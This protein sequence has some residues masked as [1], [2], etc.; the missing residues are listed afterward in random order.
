MAP[1]MQFWCFESFPLPELPDPVKADPSRPSPDIPATTSAIPPDPPVPPDP[2]DVCSSSRLSDL[3]SLPQSSAS[4]SAPPAEHVSSLPPGVFYQRLLSPSYVRL[5][6]FEFVDMDCVHGGGTIISA[7]VFSSG[8]SYLWAWPI[9]PNMGVCRLSPFGP[10]LYYYYTSSW[11][12]SDQAIEP[13]R[14]LCVVGVRIYLAVM[15]S[16]TLLWEMFNISTSSTGLERSFPP[17]FLIRKRPFP[18]CSPFMKELYFSDSNPE[19][20]VDLVTVLRS[21]VA[22]RTGPEETTE[23]ISVNFGGEDWLSTSRFKVTNFQQSGFAVKC[24]LTH[25]SLDSNS[26]SNF[27]EVLPVLIALQFM[28]CLMDLRGCFI[29]S[30]CMFGV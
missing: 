4:S 2:P 15:F 11:S 6:E 14:L 9:L 22:V 7:I 30:S 26:L 8:Y 24:C 17:S 16:S 1:L 21:C 5:C 29:P 20:S 3:L 25:S 18:S 12:P 28:L 13:V 27:F 19:A 23:F 10:E